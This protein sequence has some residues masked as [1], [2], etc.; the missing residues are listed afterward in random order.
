VTQAP[1]GLYSTAVHALWR[2]DAPCRSIAELTFLPGVGHVPMV[3]DPALIANTIL[4]FVDRISPHP[5]A[6]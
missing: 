5:E 2:A 1:H 6:K 4:D 3:D